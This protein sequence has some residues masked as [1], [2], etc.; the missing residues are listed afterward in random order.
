MIFGAFI[1]ENETF[2]ICT[3]KMKRKHILTFVLLLACIAANA[4]TWI[5]A[6]EENPYDCT[7]MIQNPTCTENFGWSR[8]TSCAAADYNCHNSEFD[9]DLYSGYCIEAWFWNPISN[10]QYTWQ[11]VEGLL[12]GTYVMRAYCA[13]QV[14]NNSAKK[15]KCVG[16][17]YLF[18][19]TEQTDITSATWQEFEVRFTVGKGETVRMGISTGEGNENDWAGLANVRLYCTGVTDD[20]LDALGEIGLS[21]WNDIRVQTADAYTNV[22]LSLQLPKDSIR[23]LCLP[24]D[25][26]EDQCAELFSSIQEIGAMKRQ[27]LYNYIPTLADTT[28]IS[29]GGMYIVKARKD[30]EQIAAKGALFKAEE[31]QTTLTSAFVLY[32][33]YRQVRLRKNM[34]VYST[35][36]GI[37]HR[38]ATMDSCKA[39]CVYVAK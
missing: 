15:G 1:E 16:P 29:A 28:A 23:T 25:L 22:S 33:T 11:D 32:G 37:F 35:A 39:F 24:F 4:Q 10:A 14:Y 12:P 36:D 5:E 8:H 21:E 26:D 30:I 27:G 34:Y 13:A 6:S 17:T 3:E 7:G 20:A 18:A 31:P 38:S 19:G 2:L 9:S